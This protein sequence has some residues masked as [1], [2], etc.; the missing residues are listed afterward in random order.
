[1]KYQKIILIWFLSFLFLLLSACWLDKEKKIVD[2][3]FEESYQIF[4]KNLY[5]SDFKLENVIKTNSVNEELN[6]K[7]YWNDDFKDTHL[8]FQSTWETEITTL[9]WQM[10]GQIDISLFD[11]LTND[12]TKLSW[13]FDMIDFD[14]ETFIKVHNFYFDKWKWNADAKFINLL[15][16]TFQKKRIKINIEN[17]IWDIKKPINNILNNYSFVEKISDSLQ[18]NTIFENL[19]ESKYDW[20]NAFNIWINKNN[21]E[22]FLK[23]IDFFLLSWDISNYEFEWKLVLQDQNKV[24]LHIENLENKEYKINWEIWNNR[25]NIVYK[26]LNNQKIYNINF[27]NLWDKTKINIWIQDKE[28]TDQNI[29]WIFFEITPEISE[30]SINFKVNWNLQINT[31]NFWVQSA[32]EMINLN[33]FGNYKIQELESYNFEKPY[34]YLLLDQIIWDQFGIEWLLNTT[35]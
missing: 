29:I 2:L 26:N 6:L 13:Y 8:I 12:V 28:I 21:F 33:V 5:I 20:Y 31:I 14:Y 32:Q 11:D 17:K 24:I 3:S 1:M 15:V 18:K 23:E 35:D 34:N 25:W 30:K 16:N 4:T 10:Y 27:T 9:N 22:K 19:W 7:I